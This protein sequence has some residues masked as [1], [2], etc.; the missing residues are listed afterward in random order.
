APIA[1]TYNRWMARYSDRCA[2]GA[3]STH[4][5][6]AKVEANRANAVKSTG[7]RSR[8]GKSRSSMNA[9]KHGLLA[10]RVVVGDEDR[11]VYVELRGALQR[12]LQPV[13]VLEALLVE[14]VALQLW[15]LR[16]AAQAEGEIVEIA[17][18]NIGL[19][20]RVRGIAAPVH[21]RTITDARTDLVL[22][23]E[24]AAER[25]LARTLDELERLQAR[26]TP[27]ASD[28]AGSSLDLGME[29]ACIDVASEERAT[30]VHEK[31]D[32]RQADVLH[33]L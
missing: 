14:R 27:N 11:S 4:T 33:E 28:K 12:D 31:P 24:V 1:R 29:E 26:R 19:V 13:G 7:P 21:S 9:L 18:S 23:Y 25:L 5:S 2:D 8:T 3:A 32:L 10:R 22:R 15:R 20:D 17:V 16:R 30:F 6:V